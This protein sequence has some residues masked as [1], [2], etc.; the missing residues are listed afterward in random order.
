MEDLRYKHLLGEF[1]GFKSISADYRFKLEIEKTVEWLH[2]LFSSGG[3]RVEIWRRN[4]ANPVVFASYVQNQE[5]Q[6]VLVYGH[7]DVQPAEEADGWRGDPFELREYRGRLIARGVVDNKG[8]ILIHLLTVIQL[9]RENQLRYNIKFLIEGN[10]ESNEGELDYLLRSNRRKLSTDIVLISDGELSGSTPVIEASLRGGFD[11]TLRYSTADNNLHSGVY[12]GAVPNAAHELSVFLA[13][14]Y[15]RRNRVRVP[16]FY[17]GVDQITGTQLKNNRR[18]RRLAAK[19]KVNPSMGKFVGEKGLDFYTQT[20]LR[21]TIQVTGLK[22]GYLGDGYASV[23]PATAEAKM[24]VRLVAS[25]EPTKI[26]QCIRRFVEANTPRYVRWS[27]EV[28]SLSR[29]VKIDT[30]T[31]VIESI[32]RLLQEIYGSPPVIKYVGAAVPIVSAMQNLLTE[33]ILLIPLGNEDCNMHGIE[34]NLRVAE[35]RKALRFS[36]KFFSDQGTSAS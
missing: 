35:L 26:V 28:G 18:L 10:E 27:T 17:A 19:S 25:Q 30:E 13:K 33:N 3:F 34:E 32:R 1:V 8:Q 29:P 11:F 7:Y 12:G 20:G 9:A 24:D 6:T 22:S 5:E 31:R 15:D 16:G 21:P 14:L 2:S 23:V 4:K 36:A